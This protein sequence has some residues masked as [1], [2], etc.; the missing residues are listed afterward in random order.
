MP[1]TPGQAERA[2]RVGI[3]AAEYKRQV[4]K[5]DAYLSTTE[6]SLS[7]WFFDIRGVSIHIINALIVDYTNAGWNVVQQT[8]RDG[9]SLIFTVNTRGGTRL[10]P[11]GDAR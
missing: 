10:V 11:S 4:D 1:V 3:D 2:R 6:P 8:D 9:P 7:G 5:I